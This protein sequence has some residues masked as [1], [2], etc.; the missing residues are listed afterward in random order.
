MKYPLATHFLIIFLFATETPFG[1]MKTLSGVS[2][3]TLTAALVT[4][5]FKMSE[6]A[7]AN[8]CMVGGPGMSVEADETQFGRKRKGLKGHP[9]NVRMDLWGV[10]CRETGDLV[11]VPFDKFKHDS[12]DHRFGP[13]SAKEVLPL[14]R[15]WIKPGGD[16][17]SDGLKCYK[18]LEA[19]G[20]KVFQ[21][22]HK[23]TFWREEASKKVHSQ[24]I[25]GVWGII[26]NKFRGK[27]GVRCLPSHIDE[28]V[29]RR[30]HRLSPNLFIDM[31][32]LYK[33]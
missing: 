9:T 23:Q 33:L 26:K 8:L 3:D 30:Q 2:R 11:L 12:A 1:A 25:D 5:R 28:F 20:S 24:T 31:V 29:W 22:S 17:F 6:D 10:V 13:A 16:F 4:I 27:F 15:R 7:T 19:E 14:A 18:D 21:V 32:R